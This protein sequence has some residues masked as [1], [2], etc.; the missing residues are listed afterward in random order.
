MIKF[1]RKNII[2]QMAMICFLVSA[3]S[4]SNY[5]INSALICA[6]LF[7]LTWE[8]SIQKFITIDFM[9]WS[10]VFISVYLYKIYKLKYNDNIV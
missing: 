4:K 2:F 8:Y 10:V 9:I 1:A 7:L 3:L 6:Y 5:I